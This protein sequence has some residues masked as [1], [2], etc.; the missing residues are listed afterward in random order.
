M[1]LS[2]D[3][4]R[5]YVHITTANRAFMIVTG[6]QWIT[7]D[8]LHGM[9]HHGTKLWQQPSEGRVNFCIWVALNSHESQR[10]AL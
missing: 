5:V 8:T 6:K 1:Y 4:N 7:A 10:V 3:E 9:L 2:L